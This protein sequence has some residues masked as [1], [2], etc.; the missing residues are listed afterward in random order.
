[1]NQPRRAISVSTNRGPGSRSLQ[2]EPGL[3]GATS[4][5]RS[6][7]LP[8]V[9]VASELRRL[10]DSRS[11][12]LSDD[13]GTLSLGPVRIDLGLAT[14]GVV[15]RR[16]WAVVRRQ[17]QMDL[18]LSPVPGHQPFTRVEMVARQR[19][20]AGRRYFRTGLQALDTLVAELVCGAAR[21]QRAFA[22]EPVR[23]PEPC[24]PA[25]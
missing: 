16:R 4:F 7:D 18:E 25:C 21:Q 19:V 20:R 14:V 11:L 15:L 8:F 17:L 1:M 13:G 3:V 2:R 5:L 10:G 22:A 23:D 12:G 6:V 24:R 9:T